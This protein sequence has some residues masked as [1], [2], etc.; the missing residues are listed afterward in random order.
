LF[1]IKKKKKEEEEREKE[2]IPFL[3]CFVCCFWLNL[4]FLLHSLSAH[5]RECDRTQE[6]YAQADS[7]VDRTSIGVHAHSRH[8]HWRINVPALDSTYLVLERTSIGSTHSKG[9]SFVDF[10]QKFIFGPF[11]EFLNFSFIFF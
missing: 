11:C 1:L 10:C 4:K 3:F 6:Q 2:K 5:W 9:S 8:H 7:A